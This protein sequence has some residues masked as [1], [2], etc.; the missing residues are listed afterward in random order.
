ME[1]LRGFRSRREVCAL[2]RNPGW[3]KRAV[4]YREDGQMVW[5]MVQGNDA[6]NDLMAIASGADRLRSE[7]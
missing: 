5:R 2:L 3:M 1:W 4:G 6:R 7:A